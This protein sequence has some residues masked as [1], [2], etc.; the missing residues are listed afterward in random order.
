MSPVDGSIYISTGAFQTSSLDEILGICDELNFYHIELS[1]GLP[2][3][4]HL[5]ADIRAVRNKCRCLVHNYFPPPE[6][7]FVLNLAAKDREILRRT[8]EHCQHAI[9]LC[10][11]LGAP[12]FS[13]HSGFAFEAAPS[14][15]GGDLRDAP[16]YPLAEAREIFIDSL[17]LLCE[18]ASRHHV[19]LAI[20]NNVV[21]RTN[22]IDGKNLLLL[23]ATADDLLEICAAVHSDA[24][25]LLIDVG[26]LRVTAAALLFDEKLFLRQL[27]SRIVAFHLNDNDGLSDSNQIFDE[28][29]WFIPE[30]RRYRN[31]TMVIESYALS[32]TQL[33]EVIT[34]VR[35]I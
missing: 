7:P 23:G 32:V 27:E 17:R 20:E 12:F 33:K 6:V 29:A 3:S 30:L 25:G 35:S 11:E 16:R 2:W 10:A 18:L 34:L 31:R 13:V 1:S 22:L 14:Q 5:G 8:R 24:L 28:N 26:H 21:T 15:L 19:G 9:T 4:D